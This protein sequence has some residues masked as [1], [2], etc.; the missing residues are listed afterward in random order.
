LGF[1][2]LDAR[3]IDGSNVEVARRFGVTGKHR[4][5]GADLRGL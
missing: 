3:Q 5:R 2:S 1:E 4:T